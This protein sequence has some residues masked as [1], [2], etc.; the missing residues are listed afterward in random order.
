MGLKWAFLERHEH[1][2]RAMEMDI[3]DFFLTRRSLFLSLLALEFATNFTGIGEAYLILKATTAH[4][5]LLAAYL[6]ESANRAVQ[7]AFAF[8]PFGL[9]VDEGMTAATLR[10]LGYG[11]SEGVSLAIIRKIRTVFWVA[12]GLLSAAKYSFARPEREVAT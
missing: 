8:V 1:D 5:S 2:L 9:G 11:A 3:Y 10:A 7:L 12:L 6:V 4:A